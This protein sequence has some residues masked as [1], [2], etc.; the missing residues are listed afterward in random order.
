M[1]LRIFLILC[2]IAEEGTHLLEM[3]DYKVGPANFPMMI[4]IIMVNL[5]QYL[6]NVIYLQRSFAK[7]VSAFLY[8]DF[9]VIY[10]LLSYPYYIVKCQ[11][12]VRA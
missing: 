1:A 10:L 5:I 11:H 7:T 3:V 4:M 2:I 8:N 9:V 12:I 6:F